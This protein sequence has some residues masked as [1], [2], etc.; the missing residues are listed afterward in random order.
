[1]C[2]VAYPSAL[3]KRRDE[4]II[5]AMR[6]LV[7][8]AALIAAPAAAQSPAPAPVAP[9]AA[10]PAS[11]GEPV[12]QPAISD[13]AAAYIT[14]GQ[15]E[16]G[17]RSWYLAAPS[18][19]IQVKA[20]NDY[21]ISA[22]V[23]G[24]VPTWQLFRT[25]TSWRECG[26]QPF[27][28]PPTSEWPHIIQTLRYIR[29]YVIPAVGPVEPVSVY[30]N[31]VLNQCAGG[32][33]ESAHK[34]DSAI[35]MVP[36]KP[37]TREVL[38]KTLCDVHTQHG[39][40]YGAGLGFYAFLRFHVDSTKFRRW[41][42][43]PAVAALCPPIIHPGDVASVGQPIPPLPQ[44]TAATPAAAQPLPAQPQAAETKAQTPVSPPQQS[45]PIQHD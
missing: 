23:A 26:A 42:M 36:L 1:M 44:T 2:G 30:R 9:L 17:Y 39:A 29:D 16:P 24:I 5:A 12:T 37:I 18:R 6:L 11:P 35:D 19:A 3:F 22:D 15:D 7:L 25:A 41:N 21:L 38:M 8:L 4:S 14:V 43:D 31:P 10:T 27:E 20:F 13:P 33:P 32:A 40:A 34:Q 45:S 28:V